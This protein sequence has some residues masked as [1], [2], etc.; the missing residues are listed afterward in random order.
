MASKKNGTQSDTLTIKELLL[1]VFVVVCI[2]LIA[3]GVT[4]A[5]AEQSNAAMESNAAFVLDQPAPGPT[6]T[7][8]ITPTLDPNATSTPTPSYIF[9]E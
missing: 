3:I 4:Q 6:L 7:P 9:E 1:P 8:S 2:V 5:L